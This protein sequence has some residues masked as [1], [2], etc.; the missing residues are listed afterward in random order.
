MFKKIKTPAIIIAAIVTGYLFSHLRWGT[1]PEPAVG[2]NHP[3]TQQAQID[4]LPPLGEM[5]PLSQVS[6]IE[7]GEES[8]GSLKAEGTRGAAEEESSVKRENSEP[9]VTSGNTPP[10]KAVA[11]DSPG[12]VDKKDINK[13]SESARTARE[14]KSLDEETEGG[15][16]GS[17]RR[18]ENLDEFGFEKADSSSEDLVEMNARLLALEQAFS[19]DNR[20]SKGR[21]TGS[22]SDPDE[23]SVMKE[24]LS[25]LYEIVQGLP[26]IDALEVKIA[27]VDKAVEEMNNTIEMINT[28]AKKMETSEI[29]AALKASGDAAA[30]ANEALTEARKISEEQA[31]LAAKIK[32]IS[33]A[34]GVYEALLS[35]FEDEK[36]SKALLAEQVEK[37]KLALDA[38]DKKISEMGNSQTS[39]LVPKIEAVNRNIAVI[40][41]NVKVLS[42]SYKMVYDNALRVDDRLGRLE[43]DGDRMADRISLLEKNLLPPE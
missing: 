22:N 40:D 43:K 12:T 18:G 26:S 13:M 37:Q 23:I 34:S 41:K 5:S 19:V 1:S 28:V 21:G 30:A 3:A 38:L 31:S 35:Q 9:P 6:P 10:V 16:A 32:E 7:R 42:T 15:G 14:D 8:S 17:K 11:E 24:S 25:N 33:T 27:S 29:D 2:V 20:R 39:D 4:S 36:K